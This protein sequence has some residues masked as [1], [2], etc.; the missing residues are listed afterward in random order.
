M[1]FRIP[2]LL[3]SLL[4]VLGILVAHPAHAWVEQTVRR[5]DA[6]LVLMRN[7]MARVQH[8]ISLRVNGGPLRSFDVHIADRDVI[9]VGEPTFVLMG[10]VMDARMPILVGVEQRSDGPLC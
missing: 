2:T 6:R 1:S 3:V 7:G 4:T 10:G 8:T 9:L 5:H